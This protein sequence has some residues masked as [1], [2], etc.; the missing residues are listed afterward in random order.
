MTVLD[1]VNKM[2]KY[3][4]LG[5]SQLRVSELCLGTMTFGEEMGIGTGE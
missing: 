2:L 3:I 5:H 1:M 4:N